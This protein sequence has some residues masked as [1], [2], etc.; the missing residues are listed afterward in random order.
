MTSRATRV[1]HVDPCSPS[2]AR[3]PG[4]VIWAPFQQWLWNVQE[5]AVEALTSGPQG[6]TQ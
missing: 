6:M 1:V 2:C 4:V 5:V 3:I